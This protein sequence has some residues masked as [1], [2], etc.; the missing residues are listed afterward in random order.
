MDMM[1]Q[2]KYWSRL[3]FRADK[4]SSSYTAIVSRAA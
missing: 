3:A 1:K 4:R 2:K